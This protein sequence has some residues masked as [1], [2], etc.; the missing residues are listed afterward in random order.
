MDL[1]TL[2]GL[3]GGSIVVV[4]AIFVGGSMSTFVDIP[5]VLI[6]GVGS[7]FVVAMKFS[8]SQLAQAF[9]IAFKAFTK[10]KNDPE[11]LIDKLFE[12][13]TTAQRKGGPLALE[14]IPVEDPFL[15]KGVQM[16]VDGV[17]ADVIRRRLGVSK[18]SMISRHLEG[19]RIFRA[20][21]EVAPG[22]GMIGTLIG[23]VQM[24]ANMSDAESIGPAMA[25]A[26]LTTLYGSLIANMFCIPIADKL[27]MLTSEEDMLKSM[28]IDALCDI[29][30]RVNPRTMLENLENYLSGG[31]KKKTPQETERGNQKEE[32]KAA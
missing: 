13:A 6:V 17:E 21:G 15:A 7:L 22:M 4:A 10:P 19:Q 3:I 26:L 18:R 1:A 20:L 5:S 31:R 14:G 29:Q 11:A 25:I 24:L 30:A 9:T 28:V 32:K 8:G 23:L 12:L 16:V 2:I 27:Q